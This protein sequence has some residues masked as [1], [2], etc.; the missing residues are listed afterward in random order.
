MQPARNYVESL[1]RVAESF[2]IGAAGG[3]LFTLVGF[4]AGWI[5]GSMLFTAIAALA[6]RPIIVPIWLAR[7]FFISLGISIGA[8]ATPETL[9]S[10]TTWPA[11]LAM[12]CLAMVCI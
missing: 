8:V 12:I 4:P 7:A 3:A 11:S 2:A 6:G 10:M 5:A 9:S 1:S